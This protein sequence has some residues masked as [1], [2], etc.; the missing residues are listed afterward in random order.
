MASR[1]AAS[2]TAEPTVTPVEARLPPGAEVFEPPV[3]A[4][5]PE[6]DPEPPVEVEVPP[7]AP[8]VPVPPAAR[9]AVPDGRR[10]KVA[11]PYMRGSAAVHMGGK[12]SGADASDILVDR[13][14]VT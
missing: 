2:A 11:F 7:V 3:V 10:P 12:G 5:V 6:A 14:H 8:G 9:A 1:A 4:P 13:I